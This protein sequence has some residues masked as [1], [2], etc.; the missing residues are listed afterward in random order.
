MTEFLFA[1]ISGLILG[2]ALMYVFR[3][4]TVSSFGTMW[5]GFI[6]Y[7]LVRNI[8][9]IGLLASLGGLIILVVTASV[10][11]AAAVFWPKRRLGHLS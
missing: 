9:P 7:L 2:I 3:W 5:L 1:I 11:V 8:N 4:R 6:L 10:Y